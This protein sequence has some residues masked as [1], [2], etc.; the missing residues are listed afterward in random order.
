MI[1]EAIPA[2]RA[3]SPIRLVSAVIIPA[4]KVDGVW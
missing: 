1:V 4:P 2:I 3:M